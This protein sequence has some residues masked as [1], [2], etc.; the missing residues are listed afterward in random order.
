MQANFPLNSNSGSNNYFVNVRMSK[1]LIMDDDDNDINYLLIVTIIFTMSEYNCSLCY[2]HHLGLPP[3]SLSPLWIFKYSWFFIFS[4]CVL[5]SLWWQCAKLVLLPF[6]TH[7]L[8]NHHLL[9]SLHLYADQHCIASSLQLLLQ[10][11]K[12]EEKGNQTK[13]PTVW[14]PTFFLY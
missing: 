10:G 8:S 14:F 13:F 3:V 2:C 1:N 6:I 11:W 5:V 7:E 4:S 9:W 12:T